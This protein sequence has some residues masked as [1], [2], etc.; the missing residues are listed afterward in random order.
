MSMEDL[1]L[2]SSALALQFLLLQFVIL[3][4]HLNLLILRY[5][6]I[7]ILIPLVMVCIEGSCKCPWKI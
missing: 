1:G 7:R 6:E 4:L 5:F 3:S 2:V